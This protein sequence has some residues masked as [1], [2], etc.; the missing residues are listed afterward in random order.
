M[1]EKNTYNSYSNKAAKIK[2]PAPL[3][4]SRNAENKTLIAV[5]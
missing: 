2:S 5:H 4:P 1:V 3:P